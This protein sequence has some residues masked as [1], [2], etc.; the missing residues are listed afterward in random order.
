MCVCGGGGWQITPTFYFLP[1]I[2]PAESGLFLPERNVRSLLL[3]FGGSS[4][5]SQG[6]SSLLAPSMRVKTR[7]LAGR[8]R[9][10]KQGGSWLGSAAVHKHARPESTRLLQAGATASTC[11]HLPPPASSSE[12]PLL[13]ESWTA[14]AGTQR[15]K[16]KLGS[17][18]RVCLASKQQQQEEGSV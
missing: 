4:S 15:W 8:L 5:V 3:H 11:L 12:K 9:L 14:P 17:F 18:A 13:L 10:H 1:L 7:S 6:W 2:T 16:A